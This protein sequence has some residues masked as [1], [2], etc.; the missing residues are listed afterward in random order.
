MSSAAVM[1]ASE[2]RIDLLDGWRAL[3]ILLVLAG[4]LLPLGPSAWG[5]NGAA[6]G[7]G[8]VIFF[9]LSG[10][11]IARML[12]AH[13][14]VPQ[15]L[16][17]RIFRIVPL[18]WVAML[19]L[20]IWNRPDA[21]TI[22]ANFGF[23]ANLPPTA[24]MRGGEHLWSLCVEMQFYLGVALLVLLA[25]RRGLYLLPFAAIAVTAL[26]IAEGATMSIYTWQRIDEILT[27]ATLAILLTTPAFGRFAAK[28]PR[29]T[30]LLLFPLVVASAHE[31][32]GAL[33]YARPYLS[34][35]MVGLSLFAAPAI[36]ATIFRSAPARYVATTSYALYVFH[37]IL[38]ATPFNAAEGVQRYVNRA[39]VIAATFALAHASTFWF[40]ARMT[41]LGRRLA[42]RIGSRR[43]PE[44]RVRP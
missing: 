7:T 35:A 29:L 36:M 17:R 42:N 34:A 4:H 9:N 26:R 20:V 28:L 41:V 16:I 11:L 27:G 10:F 14:D 39:L 8:M 3:S 31:Q 40:E 6:A 38:M 19:A 13:P 23:V 33:A 44:A 22:A 1:S 43:S 15:F 5:L 32:A 2:D 24:L 18:A 25:G 21:A 12:L 37:G 30:P